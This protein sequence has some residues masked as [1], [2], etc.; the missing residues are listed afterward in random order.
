MGNFCEHVAADGGTHLQWQHSEE[1]K[2]SGL[3][4]RQEKLS[5]TITR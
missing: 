2:Q 5:K 3:Y 1:L 4:A